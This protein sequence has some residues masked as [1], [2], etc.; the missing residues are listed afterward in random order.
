MKRHLTDFA[1]IID[2]LNF[3]WKPALTIWGIF[4]AVWLF[5]SL[6]R[7]G[8]QHDVVGLSW[9]PPGTPITFI[10]VIIVF[11]IS[12]LLSLVWQTVRSALPKIS[13]HK[14]PYSDV[15]FFLAFWIMAVLLWSNQPM[16]PTHFSPPSM[17]PNNE[18]YPNSDAAVFDTSSYHLLYGTGFVDRLIRRPVYVEMLALFHSMVGGNYEDT[19][20]L[21]ILVLALIPGVV[22]LFT[23]SLSNRMAGLIAGG[24]ILLREK[25][26]IELSGEIVTSHAK[27]MMSDMMAMLGILITLYLIVRWWSRE[28]PIGLEFAIIGSCL[29]LTALVRAQVLILTA[30]LLLFIVL[31]QKPFKLAIKNSIQILLGI[32]LVMSP[33][34]LRNWNLTGTFVLD[35]RGE[36]RLLARNYS[37]SPLSQPSP[38]PGETVEEFSTRLKKSVLTFM[39]EHPENVA[40]FVTNHFLRNLATSSVYIAP[41]YSTASPSAIVEHLPFW[42]DWN[43]DLTRNSTVALFLNLT[44]IALGTG[45]A[46]SRNNWLGF[47][48][49]VIFLVYSFGNALVRSS[50]W[51]FNQPADWIILVYYSIALAYLPSK[52]I[53]L[54]NRNI[55]EAQAD[56]KSREVT[57]FLP[58][59]FSLLALFLMGASVPIAERLIPVRNFDEYTQNSKGVLL[60]TN[61]SSASDLNAFLTEENAVITS[62]IALYPRYI[63]LKSRFRPLETS[64]EYEYLHIW[65]INDG[66]YQVVLPLQAVPKDIPHTATISIIGCKQE[67]YISAFA[68][69]VHEP[70]QEIILRDPKVPL[71]C[72][73]SETHQ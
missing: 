40:H 18:T 9:G 42:N 8:F 23:S 3:I 49:L 27:L 63:R 33:W 72:P 4:L 11:A 10:Q 17:P 68:V 31:F 48:P 57:T 14:F 6:S 13:S 7:L 53:S 19:V 5:I 67:N 37:L 64:G 32:I 73:A 15:T 38:Y 26:S 59:A 60:A 1:S 46:K 52:I 65:L 21:Q 71:H 62:G 55:F 51:R 12:F 34:V 20:F 58:Q 50:G 56:I 44:L 69:V 30:P 16:Y 25:N 39:L 45:V 36:E 28:K 54:F 41:A 24:L 66:D 61:I 70:S 47:F 29:G 2:D 22:Y 43:G 35:D